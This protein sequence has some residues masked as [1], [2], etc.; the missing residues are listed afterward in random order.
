VGHLACPFIP[1]QSSQAD[2]PDV[3]SEGAGLSPGDHQ[4]DL[5]NARGVERGSTRNVASAEAGAK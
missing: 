4:A 2:A 3:E 5:A 1:S